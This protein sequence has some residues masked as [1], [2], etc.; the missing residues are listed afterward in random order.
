MKKFYDL[1]RDEVKNKNEV[2]AELDQ[3]KI[4][5]SKLQQIIPPSPR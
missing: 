2:Q 5:Y 1:Y 3:L 4:Q